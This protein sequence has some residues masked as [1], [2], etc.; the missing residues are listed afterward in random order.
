MKSILYEADLRA[1]NPVLGAYGVLQ[2][3]WQERAL[4]EAE[5]NVVQEQLMK[6]RLAP[7][8]SRFLL[9]NYP[10]MPPQPMLYTI[11]EEHRQPFYGGYVLPGA[12][13]IDADAM[14]GG[15]VDEDEDDDDDDDDE[16][17][18]LVRAPYGREVPSSSSYQSSDP[19]PNRRRS[20]YSY[21]PLLHYLHY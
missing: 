2:D 6:H 11:P 1:A 20:S 14:V 16:G 21:S 12:V 19:S 3:L 4:A 13:K 7:D 17:R 10:W 18:T 5:L 15:K 9:P 8:A